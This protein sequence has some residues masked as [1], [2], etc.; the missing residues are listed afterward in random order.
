MFSKWTTERQVESESGAAERV[1]FSVHSEECPVQL[2]W[3]CQIRWNWFN[4]WMSLLQFSD[5]SA[6]T[7]QPTK[8]KTSRCTQHYNPSQAQTAVTLLKIT[9]ST[10]QFCPHPLC[11]T[12]K[13]MLPQG[14]IRSWPKTPEV[15]AASQSFRIIM[16]LCVVLGEE[17]PMLKQHESTHLT[18]LQ[19]TERGHFKVTPPPKRQ[20]VMSSKALCTSAVGF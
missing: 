3:S 9:T 2:C 17:L 6:A 8:P 5:A 12:K 14:P 19:R 11:Q 16:F 4:V 7:P 13:V 20:I 15:T 18:A 10:P 1:S